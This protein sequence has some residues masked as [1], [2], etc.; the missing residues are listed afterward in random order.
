MLY[1]M[2]FNLCRTPKYINNKNVMLNVKLQNTVFT[3]SFLL[4]EKYGIAVFTGLLFYNL[5]SLKGAML[6]SSVDFTYLWMN[7]HLVFG[8]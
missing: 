5:C 4:K 1:S 6:Q 8:F 2:L 7:F 3:L